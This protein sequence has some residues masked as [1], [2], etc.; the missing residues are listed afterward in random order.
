[1]WQADNVRYI[2]ENN[3]G[4]LCGD[5]ESIFVVEAKELVWQQQQT[6]QFHSSGKLI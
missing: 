1:M 5:N 2:L 6:M 3:G 4:I